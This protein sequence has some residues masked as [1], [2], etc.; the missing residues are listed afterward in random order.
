[1]LIKIIKVNILFYN[2]FGVNKRKFDIMVNLIQTDGCN[3]IISD[4]YIYKTYI[5]KIYN[6]SQLHIQNFYYIKTIYQQ[7]NYKKK[8]QSIYKNFRHTK[9]DYEKK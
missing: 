1:M 4:H 2:L 7:I 9:H 5:V 6:L 3:L 8:I